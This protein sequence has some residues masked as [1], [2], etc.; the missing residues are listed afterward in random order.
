ML[1][2]NCFYFGWKGPIGRFGNSGVGI[3]Q[4]PGTVVWNSGL[5]K[6]FAVAEHA[7]LRLEATLNNILNHPNLAPPATAAN[8]ASFGTISGVQTNEG[9]G[10]R[11]VQLGMR[12]D[13]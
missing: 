1:Q 12:L 5:A 9:A 3:L 6:N 10:A 8:A 13:F 4:G 11:T 7:H 2:G